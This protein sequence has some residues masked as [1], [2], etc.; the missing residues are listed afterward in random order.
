MNLVDLDERRVADTLIAI[1][2]LE[3]LAL[4]GLLHGLMYTADLKNESK[5]VMGACGSFRSNP[6]RAAGALAHMQMRLL[7]FEDGSG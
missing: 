1:E 7:G 3:E 2:G 4:D 6:Y 5:P